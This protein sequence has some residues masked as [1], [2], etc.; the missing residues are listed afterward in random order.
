MVRTKLYDADTVDLHTYPIKYRCP[1]LHSDALEDSQHGV[2][3]IIEGRNAIIGSLPLFQA[4]GNF[5][6]TGVGAHRRGVRRVSVAR[7]LFPPLGHHLIYKKVK[8]I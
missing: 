5:R 8:L 1:S 7:H 6:I 3:D 2:Y 4:D